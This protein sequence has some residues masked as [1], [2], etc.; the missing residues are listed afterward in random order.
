MGGCPPARSRYSLPGACRG[1]CQRTGAGARALRCDEAGTM[2]P[3][4]GLWCPAV[5]NGQFS[6]VLGSTALGWLIVKSLPF[7]RSHIA[8]MALAVIV[9]TSAAL[10]LYDIEARQVDASFLELGQDVLQVLRFRCVMTARV[11]HP[12]DLAIF[13]SDHPSRRDRASCE[14]GGVMELLYLTSAIIKLVV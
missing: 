14:D 11:G 4:R 1:A 3:A 10:V 13:D 7:V 2:P 12:F 9:V 6:E 8:C 5:L